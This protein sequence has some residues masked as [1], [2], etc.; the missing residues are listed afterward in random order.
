MRG[1]LRL[2]LPAVRIA[3]GLS[4][5]NSLGSI[6]RTTPYILCASRESGGTPFG[7]VSCG[8]GRSMGGLAAPARR[9]V[10]GGLDAVA[11]SWVFSRL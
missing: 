5:Q 9:S 11:S 7:E 2:R 1:E 8:P 3:A 6:R 10:F 4:G